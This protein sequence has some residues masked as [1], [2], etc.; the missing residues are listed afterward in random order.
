MVGV[1]RPAQLSESCWERPHG[2]GQG[3]WAAAAA[4]AAEAACCMTAAACG[5]HLKI[6][7]MC[8]RAQAKHHP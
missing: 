4:A 5:S 3:F 6:V 2:E 1:L 8:P 7:S